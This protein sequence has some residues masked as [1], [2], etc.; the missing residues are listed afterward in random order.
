M[1]DDIAYL[2]SQSDKDKVEETID[3]GYG[4]PTLQPPPI[5]RKRYPRSAVSS[6]ATGG[7]VLIV[8]LDEDITG[9]IEDEE[10][11]L[12]IADTDLVLED[13]P[14]TEVDQL[15]VYPY[16]RQVL[17]CKYFRLATAS[18]PGYDEYAIKMV[19]DTTQLDGATIYATQE[20]F[21]DDGKDWELGEYEQ[22]DYP[23]YPEG[24]LFPPDGT[25]TYE[26]PPENF[27]KKKYR[28]IAVKDANEDWVLVTALC[29]ALPAP[30]F[31][32]ITS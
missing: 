31:T 1:A 12:L 10:D 26:V 23:D 17:D 11:N 25:G 22:E 4:R 9:V 8:L 13:P 27:L 5:R 3:K 20:V 16:E 21:Y 18:D 6:P 2:L 30:A 29:K 15:N 14:G 32:E 24:E 28:G 7:D 19:L